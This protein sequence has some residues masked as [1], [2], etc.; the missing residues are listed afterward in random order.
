[1]NSLVTMN[2]MRCF[3]VFPNVAGICAIN[4][5][6]GYSKKIVVI[7]IV[8]IRS[9]V[10]HQTSRAPRGPVTFSLNFLN[11]ASKLFVITV[12]GLKPVTSCVRDQGATTAP[13]R[14]M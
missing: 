1:M 6:K 13:A 3:T 8:S 12:K 2:C 9:L 5:M 11:P 7:V 4:A 10:L 14:H